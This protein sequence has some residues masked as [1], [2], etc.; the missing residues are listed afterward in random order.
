MAEPALRLLDRDLPRLDMRSPA[1]RAK[2]HA[3]AMQAAPTDREQL[4][5]RSS[6][7]AAAL[8][9]EARNQ[10]EQMLA[11]ARLEAGRIV[12]AATAEA[13][14][15]LTE[16]RTEASVLLATTELGA[17]LAEPPKVSV[18][19]I[20]RDTARRNGVSPLDIVG[21]SRSKRIVEIR[22]AAIVEAYLQRPDLSSLQLGK[23]FGDRDHSTILH[24]VRKAGVHRGIVK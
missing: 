12:S 6:E 16:A 15:I 1:L 10:V 11:R 18:R 20:I 22:H 3:R 23:L 5:D 19:Q 8:V 24:A 21:A 2:Q 7:Y 4:R 17:A 14:L 9:S 13:H